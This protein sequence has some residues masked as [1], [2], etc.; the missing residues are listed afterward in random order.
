[1]PPENTNPDEGLAEAMKAM[2]ALI[3]EATQVYELEKEKTNVIDELYNSLKLITNFL[4]FS[5]DLH[6]DLLNLSTGSR[7]ILTPGL[8]I[9]IIRPNF[10][11]EQKRL[12]QFTLD[13][14][15]NVLRYVG[16]TLVTMAR[17]D[18]TYK[19]KKIAFLR[20]ATKKLKRLPSSDETEI[21]TD[22][23]RHVEKVES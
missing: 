11:S 22:A 7:A 18:R 14:V 20:G 16:P 15:T 9:L 5:V 1:M 3:D 10:K 8:E 19:N 17:A 21:I 13:E 6:P 12:D 2:E 23:S 4:G